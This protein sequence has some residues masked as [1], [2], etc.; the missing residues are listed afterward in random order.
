MRGIKMKRSMVW[1]MYLLIV[2]AFLI[3]GNA[4]RILPIVVTFGSINVGEIALY[5][6]ALAVFLFAK[7]SVWISNVCLA[8][9]VAS[10]LS[11]FVGLAKWGGDETAIMYNLRFVMQIVAGGMAGSALAARYRDDA[12]KV[13]TLY[14]NLYA[15]VSIFALILFFIFPDS[16]ALWT[17]LSEVGVE[18]PGDPHEG[19]LVSFYFD[20]NLFGTIIVFPIFV[21]FFLFLRAQKIK[22]L[23]YISIFFI[24]LLF[25][26]SRSGLSLFLLMSGCLFLIWGVKTLYTLK[27]NR[28]LNLIFYVVSLITFISVAFFGSFIDFILDR[29]MGLS[30]DGS[31]YSRWDSFQIGLRLL[32]TEPVLGYGY[33]FSL[34]SVQ[35]LGRIGLDSSL[36][37]VAVNYGMLI[38]TLMVMFLFCWWFLISRRLKRAGTNPDLQA[39]WRFVILYCA[40]SLIWAGNFNQILFFPFWIVPMVTLISYVELAS[41]FRAPA[42]GE[43]MREIR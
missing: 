41:H 19:R 33:N 5:M 28:G 43:E 12:E 39:L 21:G 22:V 20:P 29:F 1:S 16:S 31:A 42:Y 18:F 36:Q 9:V 32:A 37:S 2:G 35:D 3:L 4:P 23:F 11:L 13:M 8:L 14:V 30:G 24:A 25:T 10:L 38:F 17:R 15:I 27:V 7:R 6:A 34:K 26:V 40:L